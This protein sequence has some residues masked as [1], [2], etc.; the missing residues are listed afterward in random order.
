MDNINRKE[1]YAIDPRPTSPEVTD[2]KPV[3]RDGDAALD[4]LRGEAVAGEAEAIDER[5]LLRKI[6]W[7][8]VPLM[9]ACYLLQY[10][11]K[12]LLNYAAVMGIREDLDLD[13]N[14]YANL[15]LLFY[16]AFLIFELPHAYLM[17]RFP[18]AKYLGACVCCWGTVVACTSAANSYASLAA[19]RF[20]LG[21]FESAISPSLIVVTSM[22][23]KRDEQPRRVGTWYIGVG[24]ASIIGSL[25][26]FGFQHYDGDDFSSWQIM[27][28]VIGLITICVGVVVILL[29]P[30]NPMSSRLSHAE[31]VAAVERLRENQTGIENKHFKPSQVLQLAKDPQAWLLALITTAA[32]I[33]NGAV[34]SFQS[35]LIS[36]FGF[37]DYETTLLQIP[38]GVIAVISVLT[39][40]NI[41]GKFNARGLN[42]IA[43]SAIGGI[44]G[45]SLLAFLPDSNRSG[46]LAGNVRGENLPQTCSRTTS[47]ADNE[48]VGNMLTKVKQ[49]LTHVVGAFL[50]CAYSFSAAN[51]A[52]HTKKV[53]MNALLLMSFCLGNILGPLTFRTKDAPAYV[54]AK[55]TIVAV[56]SVAILSTVALLVYYRWQNTTRD[57]SMAGQ[58]HKRDI[59]FS[60]LTDIENKEFRYK[61]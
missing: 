34:G 9:F 56:D 54:P 1:Q 50:P 29:L 18:T 8:V 12:S 59:E 4:F 25:M 39:A 5:R 37:T 21:M 13:T 35:I 3:V 42:I 53:S 23:Y 22:W 32:S 40:T 26:S 6:D 55:V 61:Y 41:A 33:P 30:D 20:L 15:S 52:G 60:D 31:K 17:Q 11:D 58:D 24:C 47:V 57:R 7:M 2:E 16:V 48:A 45:G 38:G 43:W 27:F 46:K 10:L 44:L 51:H 49:Y 28:L 19:L 36:S 14:Q